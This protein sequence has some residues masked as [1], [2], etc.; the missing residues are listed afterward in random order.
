[1]NY[2]TGA[3]I[4]IR[5]RG[6][7]QRLSTLDISNA[8]SVDLTGY[9]MPGTYDLPV[10]IDLPEGITLEGQVTVSLTLEEKIVE[11]VP[12]DE[13]NQGEENN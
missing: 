13:T 3:E 11:D 8:V 10:K 9:T 6:E 1:M 2:E 4:A 12:A 7:E 5:V